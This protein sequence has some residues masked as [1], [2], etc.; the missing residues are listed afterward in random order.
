[1]DELLKCCTNVRTAL[2]E[3]RCA[4]ATAINPIKIAKADKII[5]VAEVTV[6]KLE[7]AATAKGNITYGANA[8]AERACV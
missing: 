1:M 4:Q 7:C 8:F 2:E 3:A 5:K 6:S